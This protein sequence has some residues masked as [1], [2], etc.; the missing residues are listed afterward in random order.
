MP[1][2]TSKIESTLR[3]IRRGVL[4]AFLACCLAVLVFGPSADEEL[5][6]DPSITVV[7][8]WE[9]WSGS[10]ATHVQ[11]IVDEFNRT[12]GRKKGIFVRHVSVGDVIQKTLTATAAGVPP[13][14]AGTWDAYLAPYAAL[15]ALEPLDELAAA[16]AIGP[17]NYKTPYWSGCTYRGRLY[18]LPSVGWVTALFYNKRIFHENA[19]RLRAAGLDPTRPPRT[20]A[21]L[22]AYAMALDTRDARGGIDRAGYLPLYPGF[23]IA[24]APFWFGGQLY[25]E[26]SDR[27][28]LS[29]PPCLRAFEW[30]R[31]YSQRLGTDSMMEFRSGLGGHS[32][33]QSPFLAGKVAMMMERPWVAS[34]IDMHRPGMNQWNPPAG[35][36]AAA[37]AGPQAMRQA[38][39][40]WGAAPFPSAVPGLENVCFA[41]FD[42]LV[43][44]RGAKHKAEAFEF[45][46]FMNRPDIAER[47]ASRHCTNT[48]L[49]TVSPAFL[50]DHPNPYIETFE[51]LASSP[52]A[53][54]LPPIAIWPEVGTEVGVAAEAVYLL[55]KT[56]Q[57][58]LAEAQ[59]RLQRRYDEF[60]RIAARRAKAEGR[61]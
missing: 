43:V 20:L 19:V 26:A 57:Q 25:D 50:R 7:T 56:P 38:R 49:A 22:D 51:A 34:L 14:V 40:E 13:D 59:S 11:E 46:A 55:E 53:R 48:C 28:T 60:R 18:G 10:E 21:E 4:G 1:E 9:K 52:N 47:L 17:G 5:P 29:D 42:A 2:S 33:G 32:S 45:I 3:F 23:H 24:H 54:G 44:P 16:K 37:G 15:N 8:Y 39:C 6:T 61:P 27:L 31:Q 41:G 35:F 58:A 12:V 30:I 36:E